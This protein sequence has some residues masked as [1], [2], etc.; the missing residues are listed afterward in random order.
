MTRKIGPKKKSDFCVYGLK[1]AGRKCTVDV[2][3]TSPLTDTNVKSIESVEERRYAANRY[4]EVKNGEYS[5]IAGEWVRPGLPATMP[6]CLW[7][8]TTTI[9]FLP[10][11]EG[12]SPAANTALLR[13]S[14]RAGHLQQYLAGSAATKM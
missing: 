10:W 6:S 14:L 7:L 3:I 5:K 11:L 8:G 9:K 4:V 2:G 13:R 1:R 12:A